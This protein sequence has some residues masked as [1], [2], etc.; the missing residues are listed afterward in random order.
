MDDA[1]ISAASLCPVSGGSSVHEK[2]Y[3]ADNSRLNI[4]SSYDL[5]Q[6]L[7]TLLGEGRF[8]DAVKLVR[9][10]STEGIL[11]NSGGFKSIISAAVSRG[12]TKIAVE[13]LNRMYRCGLGPSMEAMSL[14]YDQVGVE[15]ACFATS[16]LI[17]EHMSAKTASHG[18]VDSTCANM[19]IILACRKSHFEYANSLREHMIA[20]ALNIEIRTYRALIESALL[21]GR[22]NDGWT[23]L[24]ECARKKGYSPNDLTLQVMRALFKSGGLA[25]AEATLTLWKNN[26]KL[27]RTLS[28]KPD[29]SVDEKAVK[30]EIETDMNVSAKDA[31][32]GKPDLGTLHEIIHDLSKCLQYGLVEKIWSVIEEHYPVDTISFPPSVLFSRIALEAACKSAADTL[33]YI[34]RVESLGIK[35]RF[36]DLRST[37]NNL[38]QFGKAQEAAKLAREQPV[39]CLKLNVVL[40]AL[41][42]SNHEKRA[43]ELYRTKVEEGAVVP[44][45]DTIICLLQGCVSRSMLSVESVVKE[46]QKYRILPGPETMALLTLCLVREGRAAAAMDI[47]ERSAGMR[48]QVGSTSLSYIARAATLDNDQALLERLEKLLSKL[49]L[50]AVHVMPLGAQSRLKKRNKKRASSE[51]TRPQD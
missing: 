42:R 5:Q 1:E 31:L 4:G 3:Q 39:D 41:V 22:V 29:L 49:R 40:N 26:M 23:L 38:A 28:S 20:L 33:Q 17:R 50:P 27:L 15:N 14:I 48:K 34:D 19:T 32:I 37:S 9:S 35:P 43:H 47:V 16:Q 24:Q 6:V 11:P 21:H 46:L 10:S 36:K 51:R 18:Y 12:M 2:M 7:H 25:Q 13:Q 8:D 30:K 45:E 44:N